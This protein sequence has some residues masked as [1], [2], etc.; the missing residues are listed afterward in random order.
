MPRG[1]LLTRGER[2]VANAL[3]AEGLTPKRTSEP[4]T[5]TSNVVERY[6]SNPCGYGKKLFLKGNKKLTDRDR[7]AVVPEAS[8]EG[9]S[10]AQLRISLQLSFS[11][12][13]AAQNHVSYR[14]FKK[15]SSF[16]ERQLKW[17]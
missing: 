10:A 17:C 8:K 2:A 11:K 13:Q 12:R 1:K 7:W 3:T 16:M 14:S 9:S 15:G 4:I 5:R 6:L